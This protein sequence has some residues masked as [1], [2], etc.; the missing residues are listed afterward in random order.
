MAFAYTITGQT[1]FGDKKII[2]G[3]F[4]SS[5]SGTGGDI[6]TGLRVCESF[7][8]TQK[9][10]AITTGAPVVNE[11][12]PVAGGAITIVTDAD[13]VGTYVAFGY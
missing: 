3:T 10:S 4:T 8:L 5:A 9:G 12:F 2:Y 1:F 11:T 13:V 7:T 6:L